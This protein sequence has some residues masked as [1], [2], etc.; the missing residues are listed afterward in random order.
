MDIFD[1]LSLIGGLAL[2]L[3]GMNV[4]G[5]E[6][7]KSVKKHF[8]KTDIQQMERFSFRSRSDVN[9]TKFFCDHS[10]GGRICKLRNYDIKAGNRYYY[11]SQCRYNHYCMDS[12]SDGN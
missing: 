3:F 5:E 7:G 9:H 10:Y 6:S 8:G 1:F 11:G 2:F 12:Q 4:M